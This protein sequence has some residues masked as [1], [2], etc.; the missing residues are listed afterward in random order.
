[1]REKH[2]ATFFVAQV[3]LNN[4]MTAMDVSSPG[5]FFVDPLNICFTTEEVVNRNYFRKIIDKSFLHED[6]DFR[7]VGVLWDHYDET[8]VEDFIVHESVKTISN[9]ANILFAVVA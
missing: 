9:G 6:Y 1:M 5:N 2:M 8:W 4:F 3:S 7:I